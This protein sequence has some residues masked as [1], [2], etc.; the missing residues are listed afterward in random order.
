MSEAAE[1]LKLQISQL[2]SEDREELAQLLLHSL[3]Q[4]TDEEV[5]AGL[6]GRA[7]RAPWRDSQRQGD[8]RTRG[9][10]FRRTQRETRVKPLVIQPKARAERDK[11]M[12]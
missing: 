7:A 11:A 1:R 5:E 6:G 2:S 12:A 9:Q 8:W 4:G 10:S 3:D